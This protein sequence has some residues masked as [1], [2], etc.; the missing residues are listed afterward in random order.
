MRYLLSVSTLEP[1]KNYQ[2]LIQA[3]NMLKERGDNGLADL[4]LVIVGNPGWK[5][6]AILAAMRDVAARGELV[7]L[8]NVPT[9]EL[10][11][12]YAQ[13]AALVFPSNYEG[14]GFPPLEAM[15]CGAPVI[16]SNIAAH[17]WVLG[18]AALYCDPYD[19]ASI[20]VAVERLLVGNESSALRE[21]LVGRGY[22]RVKLYEEK[23][24]AR[25]WLDLLDCA[26]GDLAAGTNI[27]AIAGKAA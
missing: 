22:E 20:A 24:C 5:Y 18:D 15:Q 1:R 25:K 12:L 26:H 8:E 6:D 2:S 13:A 16:A 14:F 4:K 17:R 21:Q 9:E 19:V 7:H 3:F 23:R 27:E 10:R 11:Q